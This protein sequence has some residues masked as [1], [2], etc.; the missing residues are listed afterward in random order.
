MIYGQSF[1]PT[2]DAGQ[3]SGRQPR[4][5]AQAPIELK[6]LRLP[7]MT[8]G[9]R[10]LAPQALLQ[11]GGGAGLGGPATSNA[12]LEWLKKIL[13]P[14]VTQQSSR[15]DDQD[16]APSSGFASLQTKPQAA[17]QPFSLPVPGPTPAP[18]PAPPKFTIGDVRDNPFNVFR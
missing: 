17:P 14:A 12:V 18:S 15:D 3:G 7:S 6:S 11:S 5:G 1:Q 4:V 2:D 9:A 10:N 16:D 8:G 13:I